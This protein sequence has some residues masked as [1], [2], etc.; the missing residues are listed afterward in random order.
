MKIKTGETVGIKRKLDP[1]GRIVIPKEYRDELEIKE[2]EKVEIFLIKN[3]IFIKM[4][5]E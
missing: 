2:G 4:K 1:L 3:G 5:E